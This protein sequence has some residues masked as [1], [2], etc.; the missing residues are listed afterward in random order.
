MSIF[1]FTK[2]YIQFPDF[3]FILFSIS[4][5]KSHGRRLKSRSTQKPRTKMA[6][7]MFIVCVYA[8]SMVHWTKTCVPYITLNNFQQRIVSSIIV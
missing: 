3:F 4:C 2:N 1:K 8:R 7:Y 6:Y 5:E